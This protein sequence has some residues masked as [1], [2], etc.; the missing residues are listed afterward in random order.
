[1]SEDCLNTNGGY[2]MFKVVQV[3]SGYVSSVSYQKAGSVAEAIDIAKM[4][5]GHGGS[6]TAGHV[7]IEG[8]E[9]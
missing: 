7:E 4:Y 8:K 5:H 1:M 6:W 9:K 2:T 3:M